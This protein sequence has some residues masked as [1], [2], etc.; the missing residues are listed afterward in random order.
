MKAPKAPKYPDPATTAATQGAINSDAAITQQ[1]VNMVDQDTPDYN[2]THTENG[3]RRVWQNELR[4]EAGAVIRPA[5]FVNV[6]SYVAKT[7]LK[8]GAQ[9][10]YNQEQAFDKKFNTIGLE[11]TDKIGG[12]LSKPLDLSD[13]AIGSAISDRL[14]PRFDERFGKEQANLE[15]DLA[16]SGM[17]RGSAGYDDA[18]RQFGLNK[19]DAYTDMELGARGQVLQEMMSARSQ[20][21][22]EITALLGGGQVSQPN[23]INTPKAGVEAADYQGQVSNKYNADYNA[24]QQKMNSRNGMM[25]GLFGLGSNILGW[26]F[27][28]ERLKEDVR[29]VG[30]LDN[31]LPV[32]VYRYKGIPA[33]QMGVMAQDVEK[34]MPD[35]VRERHGYKQVDYDRV[36]E[37]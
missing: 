31:G 17:K 3:M 27:S 10:L 37:T 36:T 7:M 28:D 2:L 1:A 32:Y 6:P 34:V 21:I 33:P 12:L 26:G 4:N 5:G 14:R 11:Q 15:A 13:P 23:F 19:S 29:R 8:P 30:T 9:E 35:A 22:N 24:Y 25:S 16:N 20:P 18:L